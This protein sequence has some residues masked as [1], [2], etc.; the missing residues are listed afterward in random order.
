MA[1]LTNLHPNQRSHK[2]EFQKWVNDKGVTTYDNFSDV[3]TDTPFNLT[4]GQYVTVRNGY[5]H[6]VGPFMVLGFRKG[7]DCRHIYLD[8][9]C[10]WFAV[11]PTDVLTIEK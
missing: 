9:D 11:K 3:L 6:T 7:T 1:N 5:G 4:V 2:E 8:W 10:Y